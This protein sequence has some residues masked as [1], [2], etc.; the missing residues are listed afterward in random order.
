M[1]VWPDA[2][3]LNDQAAWVLDAYNTLGGMNAKLDELDRG[4][5]A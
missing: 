4:Q 3:G 5:T 1:A 2:G